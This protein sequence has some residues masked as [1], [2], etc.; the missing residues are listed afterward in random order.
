[1]RTSFSPRGATEL[2]NLEQIIAYY[3]QKLS[4]ETTQTAKAVLKVLGRIIDQEG[5]HGTQDLPME[6]LYLCV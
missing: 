6:E 2:A 1:M 5:I 4:E 3:Q